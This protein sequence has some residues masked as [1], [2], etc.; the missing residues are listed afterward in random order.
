MTLAEL[1]AMKEKSDAIVKTLEND[2][3][4]LVSTKQKQ[5]ED[6]TSNLQEF[7]DSL[8]EYAELIPDGYNGESIPTISLFRQFKEHPWG[9]WDDDTWVGVWDNKF[10]F[11][12]A[13]GNEQYCIEIDKNDACIYYTKYSYK[14]YFNDFKKF[15]LDHKDEIKSYVEQALENVLTKYV[16]NNKA[17]NDSLYEDIKKLGKE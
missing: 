5:I 9:F 16:Q 1:K 2:R 15:V 14:S 10:K 11:L 13:N 8:K 7:L 6:N 17:Q 12:I 3:A 4:I